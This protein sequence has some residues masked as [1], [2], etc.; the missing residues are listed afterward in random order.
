MLTLNIASILFEMILFFLLNDSDDSRF[1]FN[2]NVIF[3]IIFELLSWEIASTLIYDLISNLHHC[4]CFRRNHWSLTV[5][6]P[7]AEIVYHMDPLKR[8]IANGE[9]VEVVDK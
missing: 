2:N 9:W 7:E 8:R 3:E 5:A 6:N 4:S 1:C